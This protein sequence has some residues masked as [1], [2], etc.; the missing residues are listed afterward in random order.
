MDAGNWWLIK[1]ILAT[2][3][4]PLRLQVLIGLKNNTKFLFLFFHLATCNSQHAT[5]S[6]TN[7]KF[8]KRF[9]LCK[10]CC[11]LPSCNGIILKICQI[12]A[13]NKGN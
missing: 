7:L 1:I 13:K 3:P 10:T 6:S 9:R 11:S 2:V 12:L 4:S 8:D 5:S